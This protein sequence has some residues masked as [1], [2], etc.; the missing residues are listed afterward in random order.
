MRRMPRGEAI[1]WVNAVP[2][3]L[4]C[5]MDADDFGEALGNLLDNARKW[6][7]GRVEIRAVP[8]AGGVRIVVADDG[9]GPDVGA[10]DLRQRGERAREDADGSGL[11][12]SIVS[13]ILAAYGG[14]L[15]LG[16]GPSGGCEASFIVP[17]GSVETAPPAPRRAAQPATRRWPAPG[18]PQVSGSS[19]S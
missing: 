16:R 8:V 4:R 1:A 6:A 11:G 18:T 15:S 10:G 3:G 7:A 17:G 19:K 13:D 2:P 5:A 9:P 12:L 14:A